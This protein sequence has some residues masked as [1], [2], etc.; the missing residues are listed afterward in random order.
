M[1]RDNHSTMADGGRGRNKLLWACGLVVAVSFLAYARVW[2]AYCLADDF[3]YAGLYA[4]RPLSD[5]AEI[6]FKDWTRGIW[7]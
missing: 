2:N 6:F 3:A 1:V 4:N 7:G 5:W